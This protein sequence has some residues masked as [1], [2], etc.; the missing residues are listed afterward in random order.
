[1]A[2]AE[3]DP[4]DPNDPTTRPAVPEGLDI[5]ADD[6]SGVEVAQQTGD[7]TRVLLPTET[8]AVELPLVAPA[9]PGRYRLEI[10]VRQEG[11]AWFPGPIA[12]SV[13]VR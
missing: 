11:L 9:A 2:A 1:M 8:E 3:N 13:D 7:L 5:L 4:N 12:F 6:A 10:G